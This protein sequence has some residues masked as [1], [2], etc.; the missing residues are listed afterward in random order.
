[1]T[2]T[3]VDADTFTVVGDQTTIFVVG[4]AVKCDC[5]VDGTKY[6]WVLSSTYGDP[7]TTVNLTTDSDAITSNLTTVSWSSSLPKSLVW[8]FWSDGEHAEVKSMNLITFNTAAAA[9]DANAEL[10]FDTT[11]K[12]IRFH[13]GSELRFV[14]PRAG[15]VNQDRLQLSHITIHIGSVGAGAGGNY[16][17]FSAKET[18]RVQEVS[19]WAR[20]EAG[21]VD[22]TVSIYDDG[23]T[24]QSS[25][26]TI[27]AAATIYTAALDSRL[28]TIAEGS[29]VSVYVTT[30]AGD[31]S[32]TD[33]T[34][35]IAYYAS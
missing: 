29:T 7:N 21:A 28:T 13:D 22:G 15:A 33:V 35:D 17:A 5:G 31:G 2:G 12:R 26:V 3:Y 10:N 14:D 11:Y 18:I 6:G 34:V 27:A 20:A 30:N 8:P 4:R 23:A 9:P 25:A 24:I 16:A 19:V 1:M 32:L